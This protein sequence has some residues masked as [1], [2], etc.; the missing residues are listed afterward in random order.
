MWQGASY[1]RVRA[2]RAFLDVDGNNGNHVSLTLLQID[3]RHIL[4][5]VALSR[6]ER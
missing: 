3:K 2:N 5:P 4:D 1:G 6:E